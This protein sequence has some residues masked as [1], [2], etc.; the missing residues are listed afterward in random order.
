[1]FPSISAAQEIGLAALFAAALLGVAGLGRRLWAGRLR[2][3]E[4]V[5]AAALPMIPAQRGSAGHPMESVQLTEA[6]EQ[7]FAGLIRTIPRP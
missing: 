2:R 6:E 7:A 5:A 3:P 1:M 4:P